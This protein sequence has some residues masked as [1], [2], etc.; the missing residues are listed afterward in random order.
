MNK[1]AE[2]RNKESLTQH[3]ISLEKHP[4]RKA[5]LQ[6]DLKIIRLRLQIEDFK[7][8]IKNLQ[9]NF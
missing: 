5:K 2:L 6:N 1:E 4:N 9:I 7:E 8:R 3:A